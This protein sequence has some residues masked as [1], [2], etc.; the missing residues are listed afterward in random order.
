MPARDRVANSKR[1]NAMPKGL[2]QFYTKPEVARH[3]FDKFVEVIAPDKECAWIEPSAGAGAFFSLMPHDRRIGLDLAPAYDG[4]QEA[5]YR[6]YRPPPGR[7]VALG[8]PPFGYK[9]DLAKEFIRKTAMFSQAIGFIV[10]TTCAIDFPGAEV[11]YTEDLDADSFVKPNGRIHKV[12]GCSFVIWKKPRSE[13]FNLLTTS[14]SNR[15]TIIKRI[16]DLDKRREHHNVD[17]FDIYVPQVSYEKNF[18]AASC[19]DSAAASR[20]GVELH[21][22]YKKYVPILLN[23]DWRQ[24]AR[25]TLS[26]A[27]FISMDK[28]KQVINRIINE[29]VCETYAIHRTNGTGISQID[30]CDFFIQRSG[31]KHVP[32]SMNIEDLRV[33]V[34][35]VKLSEGYKYLLPQLLEYNFEKYA[36][37]NLGGYYYLGVVKV[38]EVINKIALEEMDNKR[39]SFPHTSTKSLDTPSA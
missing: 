39:S 25:R 18:K 14:G 22:E 24:D 28:I 26:G 3:C 21:E 20:Y 31:H 16:S 4:V 1:N 8:N 6:L 33:C 32:N 17:G 36:R 9:C 23:Y 13:S 27:I 38:R 34:V 29:G 15:T 35:G 5:D 12:P 37:K 2:D 10:P 30:N 19:I 7:Y 11:V